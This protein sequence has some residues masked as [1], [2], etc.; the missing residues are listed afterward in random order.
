MARLLL[1]FLSLFS[2]LIVGAHAAIL[3]VEVDGAIDPITSE[4]IQQAVQ[5]AEQEDAEF[6]LIRLATPGGLGISMQ[7][8]VQTILNSSVPV[9]CYVAPRG[10]HAASAG[11]F[12]L[13]SADIAAM[14]PGTNT[15]AAHPVFPFGM[16]NEVMMKKVQN[17]ALANLRSIVKQR[18]RNYEMA[19][20][21]VLESKSYTAGEALEGGLIDVIADNESDLLRQL[22][23]REITRFGGETLE[24][25][26][27]GVAVRLVEKSFR[28]R[29]LT[30]I[31]DPNF[32]LL[33]GV[34]GL[35]GLYFEFT[36]PGMIVPGVA[37]GI[38]LLLSLLGFSLLPVTLIGTLLILLAIGLFIAEATIQGFGVLGIGG[39]VSMVLGIIF[40]IDSPYPALR[41]DLGLA[42]AITIPFALISI[43]L[44]HLAIKSY[45]SRVQTGEAGLVG[46]V[47]TVTSEIA[48]EEGGRV[49]VNGE[50]WRAFADKTIPKGERVR[51]VA[52]QNLDLRVESVDAGERPQAASTNDS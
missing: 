26:T 18:N 23:G 34:I 14:A 40:L 16:E 39:I 5:T 24:L 8:I 28:Q 37:G 35:L 41:I 30:T 29:V 17:D 13:L 46:L 27:Q 50:S 25:R 19:E 4:F 9:V 15:G 47:G 32:A 43:F 2:Y 45:R 6:L 11:F 31:A 3:K 51:I 12:I 20:Q 36:A 22:D 49:F 1:V 44:A 52:A 21:G 38:C 7:E 42:L 33:L 48:P 10:V